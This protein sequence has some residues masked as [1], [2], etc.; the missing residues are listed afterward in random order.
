MIT[1]GMLGNGEVLKIV[2]SKVNKIVEKNLGIKFIIVFLK[3]VR[4]SYIVVFIN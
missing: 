4:L 2:I 3:L 1:K